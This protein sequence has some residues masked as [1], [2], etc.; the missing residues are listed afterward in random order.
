MTV[1]QRIKEFISGLIMIFGALVLMADPQT[2]YL[3]VVYLLA[4]ILL[5]MGIRRLYYY[6]TMARYMVDGK[7][8]LYRGVILFDFGALT[9]SL[10]NIPK[11]YVLFYLIVI[12]AFSGLVE[13]LRAREA[14]LQ[15]APSWRFKLIH[16]MVDLLMAIV[17]IMFINEGI[18]AVL[19]YAIGL[20]YSG[21]IRII[22]AFRKTKFIC[23]Q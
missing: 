23:I 5:I 10:T 7:E 2:G 14:R 3:L 11:F 6:F 19:I 22:S 15:G 16:G 9:G 17:C 18:I 20:I 8:S 12:H 4:I 13:V 1:V 21:L